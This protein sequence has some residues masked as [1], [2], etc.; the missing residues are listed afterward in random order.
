MLNRPI[1]I[2]LIV[3]SCGEEF[4]VSAIAQPSSVSLLHALFIAEEQG[5]ENLDQFLEIDLGGLS[6]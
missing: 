4:M 3:Q 6:E 1:M 2:H 5:S